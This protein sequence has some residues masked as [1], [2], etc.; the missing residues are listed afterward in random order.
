MLLHARMRA[1]LFF[2]PLSEIHATVV[3][4]VIFF[5]VSS[6]YL[7]VRE[8]GSLLGLLR[9]KSTVAEE[10]LTGWLNWPSRNDIANWP[11]LSPLNIKVIINRILWLSRPSWLSQCVELTKTDPILY[12]FQHAYLAPSFLPAPFKGKLWGAAKIHETFS[13]SVGMVHLYM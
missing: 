6:P 1:L 2:S 8:R 9:R 3:V 10:G 11:F 12:F 4:Q 7:C 5:P 13:A